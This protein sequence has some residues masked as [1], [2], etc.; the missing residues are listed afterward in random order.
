MEILSSIFDDT[1]VMQLAKGKH[2]NAGLKKKPAPLPGTAPAAP[3]RER[4]PAAP[5]AAPR[6]RDRNRA[7]HVTPPG[8]GGPSRQPRKSEPEKDQEK[9]DAKRDAFFGRKVKR[10]FDGKWLDCVV[11]HYRPG[12][13]HCI[14]SNHR[15][16]GETWEWVNLHGDYD[17]SVLQVLDEVGKDVL[18]GDPNERNPKSRTLTFRGNQAAAGADNFNARLREAAKSE[19]ATELMLV[20]ALRK[21]RQ[22]LPSASRSCPSLHCIDFNLIFASNGH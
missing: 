7:A 18:V 3:E 2:V 17:K 14:A 20:R 11:V 5:R 1:E 19:Q 8:G 15:K 6:E 16:P 9:E 10:F 22:A 12:Q 4:M 13:G 21:I